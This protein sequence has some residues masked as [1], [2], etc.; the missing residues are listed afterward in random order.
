MND[1]DEIIVKHRDSIHQALGLEPQLPIQ[2]T[3]LA[4]VISEPDPAEPSS[5]SSQPQP[6]V[7]EVPKTGRVTVVEIVHFISPGAAPISVESRFVRKLSTDEQP[8]VRRMTVDE[9]WQKLDL[10]WLKGSRPSMLVIE[11]HEG[12]FTQV[13]PTKE[14]RE[15]SARRVVVLNCDPFSV[16]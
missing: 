13:N 16:I 3:K 5:P 14:E 12:Q 9:K 11:N 2:V 7:I 10:G 6:T 4:Q 1:L 8:Y 15:E